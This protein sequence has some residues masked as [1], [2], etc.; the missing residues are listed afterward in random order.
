L[1]SYKALEIGTPKILDIFSDEI[2]SIELLSSTIFVA[3]HL[4]ILAIF[5]SSFLTPDSLV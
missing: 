2:L 4:H 5:F 3:I 1:F